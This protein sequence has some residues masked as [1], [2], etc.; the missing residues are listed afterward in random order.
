MGGY[1][2][3]K[4]NPEFFIISVFFLFNFKKMEN[5][6]NNDVDFSLSVKILVKR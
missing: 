3:A 5:F 4:A 2:L 1:T 6:K